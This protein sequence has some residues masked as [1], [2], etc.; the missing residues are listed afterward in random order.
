VKVWIG[1]DM[2]GV[3]GISHPDVT[4]N[5]HEGY[6]GA[7]AL[8]TA[9]ASAA[10]RGAVDGGAT[11]VIVNDGHGRMLNID[12]LGLDPRAR[13]LQGQKTWSAMEGAGPDIGVEV[14]LL[15][16]YHARAGH[17][18]GTISH[19]YT[20]RATSVRLNGKPV[21]EAG[22][23]AAVLG[24]WGVPVAMV[25]GDDTLADEIGD[26]IPWAR[27]VVVKRAFGRNA[28]ASLHPSEAQ[29]AI[30]DEAAASIRRASAAELTVLKVESP[31][32]I[33]VEYV[34]PG[35]ADYAA[36]VPG[37]ERV[38]D[39]GVRVSGVDAADAFR[40]FLCGVRMSGLVA[41]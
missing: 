27:H 14:A 10:V 19:T 2:E 29:R 4:V 15:V 34:S 37:A 6:S 39:R 18:R 13:L 12:P 23:H 20:S 21:G 24:A 25:A 28:A 38:G 36:F 33:D 17:P 32:R 41:H 35:Q 22:L 5:G 26:W 31:V 11:E 30:E 16:G 8:M 7:C 1:V 9:E 3:A 40:S